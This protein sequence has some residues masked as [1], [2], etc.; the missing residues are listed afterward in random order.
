MPVAPAAGH[1]SRLRAPWA[2]ARRPVRAARAIAEADLLAWLADE[3]GATLGDSRARA[4][5]AAPA[6]AC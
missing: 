1:Y 6:H 5:Q 4:E 3:H 2:P